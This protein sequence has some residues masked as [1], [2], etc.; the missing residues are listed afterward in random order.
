MGAE[1]LD[2]PEHKR[3]L[4][5]LLVDVTVVPEAG[6]G[7]ASPISLPEKDRP[8]LLAAV[9]AGATYSVTGDIRHFGPYRLRRVGGV[10]ICTPRDY[11]NQL[12]PPE[13]D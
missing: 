13:A 11:L 5:K 8:V 2:R 9:Q 10:I 7:I 4:G 6:P 1:N 12:E 3:R